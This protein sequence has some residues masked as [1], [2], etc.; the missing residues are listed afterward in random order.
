[1][2]FASD[3]RSYFQVIAALLRREEENRRHAPMESII[4]L[5]EPIVMIATLSFLMYFLARRQIAPLGGP[6][7]LFYATGFFPL[8][9]FIY[10]S[11]RMRG[12]I[13]APSRRFPVEQRLDHI[14]VH[15]ILRIIDYAVLGIVL[16]GGIYL[17]FTPQAIPTDIVRVVLACVALAC[18]GFGWGI[19]NLILMKKFLLWRFVNPVLQRAMMLF[20]GVF[21]VPDFLPPDI[22][23]VMSFNPLTHAIEL[24]RLGFYPHYPAILLD[25]GYLAWSALIAVFFGL[26]IE[27]VTRRVEGR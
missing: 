22:R 5:I 16:F 27:R 9:F 1:M 20:S 12:S 13:D 2:S 8:Y 21:F 3:V 24:F 18:L 11:R 6:P 19:L 25:T 10:I 15:I 7:V 4:N 14:L 17:L 23:Y 26:L